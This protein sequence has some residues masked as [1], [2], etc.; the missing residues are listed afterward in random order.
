MFN[1]RSYQRNALKITKIPN[2]VVQSDGVLRAIL[3]GFIIV[4]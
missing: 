4:V 1:V 3:N 2:I